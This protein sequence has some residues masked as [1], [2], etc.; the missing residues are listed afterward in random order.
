MNPY[1]P[2]GQLTHGVL[3]HLAELVLSELSE[4][5]QPTAVV[6]NGVSGSGKSFTADQ[7]L[8]KMFQIAHKTDWLQ[9]LRKVGDLKSQPCY[10]FSLSLSLSLSHTHTHTLTHSHTH[11]HTHTHTLI[12]LSIV[13]ASVNR[14]AES[15]WISL[16]TFQ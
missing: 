14:C 4:G 16:H 13:L 6:F 5:R 15:T 10:E 2:P 11:T 1:E 12:I 7:L 3:R 9:D 8:V